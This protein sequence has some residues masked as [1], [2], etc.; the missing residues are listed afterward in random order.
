[1]EDH[2]VLKFWDSILKVDPRGQPVGKCLMCKG[3]SRSRSQ[4]EAESP[5]SWPSSLPTSPQRPAAPLQMA[6][7]HS[8]PPTQVEARISSQLSNWIVGDNKI[9]SA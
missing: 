6:P 4:N 2:S 5:R 7:A 1:M 3:D 9:S 8:L